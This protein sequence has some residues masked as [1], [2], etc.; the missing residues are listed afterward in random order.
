M[1]CEWNVVRRAALRQGTLLKLSVLSLSGS[2]VLSSE[3]RQRSG[4]LLPTV[5]KNGVKQDKG[6]FCLT[7]ASRGTRQEALCPSSGPLALSI[8][9]IH[10]LTMVPG[11]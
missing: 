2:R 7:T 6:Q 1:R 11:I 3:V 10:L 9:N 4:P 5:Y 8:D